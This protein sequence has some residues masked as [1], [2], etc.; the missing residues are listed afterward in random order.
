MDVD[1][2]FYENLIL[3]TEKLIIPHPRMH[4]RKFVL[5]PICEIAPEFVH[6]VLR[7]PMLQLLAECNDQSAV[8]IRI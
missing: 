5:V 3:E 4:L 2:L 8:K 1:I 6:P 7:K